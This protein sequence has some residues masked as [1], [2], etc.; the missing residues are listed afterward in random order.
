MKTLIKSAKSGQGNSI[1]FFDE[2]HEGETKVEPFDCSF[3]VMIS[4]TP[5]KPKNKKNK[6]G[7]KV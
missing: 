2:K 6:T 5:I 4:A 3:V 7:G 1:T